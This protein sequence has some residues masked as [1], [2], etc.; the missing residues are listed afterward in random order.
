MDDSILETTMISLVG[1][2][3]E[4]VS[5]EWTPQQTGMKNVKIEASITDPEPDTSN[6]NQTAVVVVMDAIYVDSFE[7]GAPG[8]TTDASSLW[9]LTTFDANSPTHAFWC[10]DESD[11][12]YD[13]DMDDSLYSP[14]INLSGYDNAALSYWPVSYTHLRAHET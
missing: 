3:N 1:S 6:N 13:N 7:S 10:A 4:V 2:T 12:N 14:I 11:N 9:H 5:F 8:W